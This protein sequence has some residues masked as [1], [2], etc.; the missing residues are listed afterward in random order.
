MIFERQE[1]EGRVL[2]RDAVAPGGRGRRVHKD[3]GR[4]S[5]YSPVVLPYAAASSKPLMALASL[6]MSRNSQAE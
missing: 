1:K 3:Q 5:D 6:G 2:L 4:I